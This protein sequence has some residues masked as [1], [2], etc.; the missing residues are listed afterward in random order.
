MA[1]KIED[2]LGR[3]LNDKAKIEQN[4]KLA[5]TMIITTLLLK[6]YFG[7]HHWILN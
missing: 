3:E 4:F 1:K 2:E 5:W 6:Y 7:S